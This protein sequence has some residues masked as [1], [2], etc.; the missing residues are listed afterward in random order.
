MAH[1][2]QT[3]PHVIGVAESSCLAGKI[4][5]S[6]LIG[7]EV[8]GPTPTIA[9]RETMV[10]RIEPIQCGRG[11]SEKGNLAAGSDFPSDG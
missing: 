2:L 7:K 9:N 4:P 3:W 10:G 1:A 11:R 8:V 6:N 5:E